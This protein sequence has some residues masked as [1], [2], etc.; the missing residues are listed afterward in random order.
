MF[1]QTHFITSYPPSLLNRDD[2]GLAKRIIFGGTERLRISSQSQKRHW[3]TAIEPQ[4]ASIKSWRSKAYFS[5]VLKPM[6]LNTPV[7]APV[8][9]KPCAITEEDAHAYAYA[10][11]RWLLTESNNRSAIHPDTLETAQVILFGY[12]ETRYFVHLAHQIHQARCQQ[13]LS[14][15]E[16]ANQILNPL[17]GNLQALINQHRPDPSSQDLSPA[18]GLTGALFGRFIT[19]D[20]NARVDAPVHVAH[21]ITT[22]AAATELDFF[23]AVDDLISQGSAHMG[24]M[25]LGA[26]TYYGYVAVDIPLLVSNLSGLP[27]QDWRSVPDELPRAVL[28]ALLWTIATVSPGAKLGSTA[29]H[30]YAQCVVLEVGPEQPRTLVNAFLQP[31]SGHNAEDIG[32]QSVAALAN[33]AAQFDA[34]YHPPAFRTVST[35]Y[36]WLGMPRIPLRDAIAQALDAVWR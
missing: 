29:P 9:E 1:L 14:V 18:T 7:D 12:P 32:R 25:E 27:A 16:A 5:Q 17:R 35:L 28:H 20:I 4:F 21:A 2:A 13:N 10:I 11:G 15:E 3:R 22:H 8:N 34:M 36:D 31:I 19:S 26:G 6:I 24:D 30:A 23:T 33:H